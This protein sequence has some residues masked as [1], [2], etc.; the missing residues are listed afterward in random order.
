[1]EEEEKRAG[2]LHLWAEF[3][4]KEAIK[5]GKHADEEPVENYEDCLLPRRPLL[6]GGGGE[7]YA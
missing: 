5:P 1:M 2:G 6:G 3:I 4:L 7:S